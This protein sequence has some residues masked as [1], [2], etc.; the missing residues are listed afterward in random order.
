MEFRQWTRIQDVHNHIYGEKDGIPML[1]GATDI[2]G[3]GDIYNRVASISS[4][5]EILGKYAKMH[6]VPFGEY[7][8]L[9]DFLPNFIQFHP[10]EHGKTAEFT[11]VN[12]R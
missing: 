10:F 1:I 12:N 4:D 5:G 6:L 2:D 3:L 8:P 9:G 7:V 11:T